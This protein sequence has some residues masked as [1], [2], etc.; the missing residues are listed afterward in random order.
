MINTGDFR[1]KEQMVFGGDVLSKDG[2]TKENAVG[3]SYVLDGFKIIPLNSSKGTLYFAR[4]S[5]WGDN[6]TITERLFFPQE[7]EKINLYGRNLINN[8]GFEE[9]YVGWWN[10]AGYYGVDTSETHRGKQSIRI[11]KQSK[12]ALSYYVQK[13]QFNFMH[14]K[15]VSVR[16]G[17]WSKAKNVTGIKDTD[18]SLDF[19][20][21]Y[22]DGSSS[23]KVNRRFINCD[24]G[25][26]DWKYYEMIVPSDPHKEIHAFRVGLLFRGNHTGTVWFDDI[27]CEILPEDSPEEAEKPSLTPL[28]KSTVKISPRWEPQKIWGRDFYTPVSFTGRTQGF[29]LR[30]SPV[31]IESLSAGF[32]LAVR[33]IEVFAGGKNIAAEAKVQGEVEFGELQDI[34]HINNGSKEEKPCLSEPS[35]PVPLEGSFT[36]RFRGTQDID[37]VVLHHGLKSAGK[38]GYIAESFY[39]QYQ[40]G[41]KWVNISTAR[42]EGNRDPVT[43]LNFPKVKTDAIRVVIQRQSDGNNRLLKEIL[44]EE[45]GKDIPIRG[46]D[47]YPRLGDGSVHA[48]PRWD[49]THLKRFSRQMERIYG[50]GWFGYEQHEWDCYIPAYFKLAS[51]G[52]TSA[53][54]TYRINLPKTKKEA[55]Q[56]IEEL[57][58]KIEEKEGEKHFGMLTWAYHHHEM[59][60]GSSLCSTQITPAV[61]VW[62]MQLAFN[63]GAARQY[64]KPW[65]I[66][67]ARYFGNW[68]TRDYRVPGQGLSRRYGIYTESPDGG[69]AISLE[70]RIFYLSYLSGANIITAE[71]TPFSSDLDADMRGEL[72]PWGEAILEGVNFTKRHPERGITYT[73]IGIMLDYLH[74]WEPRGAK[75]SQSSKTWGLVPY[76]EEDFMVNGFMYTVW[77]LNWER[78]IDQPGFALRNTNEEHPWSD[79][80]DVVVP[81]FPGNILNHQILSDYRVL[82]AVGGLNITEELVS[83]LKQYVKNG[84]TLVLNISQ[85]KEGLRGEDFLGARIEDETVFSTGIKYLEEGKRIGAL[86]FDTQK[87]KATTARVIAEDDDGNP[88]ILVNSYGKGVVIFTTPLYLLDFEQKILPLAGYLLRRLTEEVLPLE[89][90]GD[91]QYIINRNEKGW[92]VGLINNNG[93]YKKCDMRNPGWGVK[94]HENLVFDGVYNPTVVDESKTSEILL[95]YPGYVYRAEELVR[96][97]PVRVSYIKGN[98]EVQLTVPPGEVRVIQLMVD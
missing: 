57:F 93:V 65:D 22:K 34:K 1:F 98:S 27:S 19:L 33:E 77:P 97:L 55:Y 29:L 70:K 86:A 2:L 52:I 49:V 28:V 43:T 24:V 41:G 40:K 50:E 10:P 20:I 75:A 89:I 45:F 80:F 3:G 11:S 78:Y 94:G 30:L 64:Q 53:G 84:G 25:T 67:L 48:S 9:G 13:T 71:G 90:K 8:P 92:V 4:A 54:K 74:G 68:N 5:V 17:M 16:I 31:S 18:Y 85:V 37:R 91:I 60:W 39:L 21:H 36:L 56:R 32:K 76:R 87:V 61:G 62:S 12:E 66:Y 47:P 14:L 69:P 35:V 46:G 96:D 95:S 73:P 82:F 79:I 23:F 26:H 38:V 6:L 59:Q 15:K 44:E 58:R 7:K 81:N 83:E 72:S 88:L 42:I 51:K 63:R